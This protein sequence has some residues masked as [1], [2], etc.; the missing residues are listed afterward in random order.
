MF[1]EVV[2]P[3]LDLGGGRLLI[4]F[5]GL[6]DAAAARGAVADGVDPVLGDAANL[7]QIGAL[8]PGIGVQEP[9]AEILP[10][11]R[12]DVPMMER[13]RPGV[14]D[15]GRFWGIAGQNVLAPSVPDSFTA[16]KV[17]DHQL[18]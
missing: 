10:L 2:R 8:R 6:D 1:E 4:T 16:T 17:R 18:C 11:L 14:I 9:R 13:R 7:E 15:R 3:I 12:I 5:G